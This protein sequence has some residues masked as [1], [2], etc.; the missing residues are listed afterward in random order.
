M[1]VMEP[2]EPRP[3]SR[4]Q[5]FRIASRSLDGGCPYDGMTPEQIMTQ[6]FSRPV[7]PAEPSP[8]VRGSENERLMTVKEVADLVQLHE[9]VIRRAIEAG[10]LPAVKIRSRV[11]IRRAAVDAWLAASQVEPS[12]HDLIP[13][14]ID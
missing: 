7:E 5:W 8:A 13:L 9:K 1:R 11:R 12:P 3:G 2:M 10:E 14:T 6:L 4:L